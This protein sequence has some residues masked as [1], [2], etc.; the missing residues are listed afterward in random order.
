MND[1]TCVRFPESMFVGSCAAVPLAG[2]TIVSEKPSPDFLVFS[3]TLPM[4]LVIFIPVVGS[5]KIRQSFIRAL[6]PLCRSAKSPPNDY[7]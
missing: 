1:Q 6:G 2:I 7:L 4:E 5:T 3:M